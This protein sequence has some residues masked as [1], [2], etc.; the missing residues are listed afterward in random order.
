MR[1]HKTDAM[2]VAL[3]ALGGGRCCSVLVHFT[4]L[5]T[6]LFIYLV[7]KVYALKPKTNSE[8]RISCQSAQNYQF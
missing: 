1:F 3:M 6:Y 5:L 7:T 2:I 4:P 8:Q